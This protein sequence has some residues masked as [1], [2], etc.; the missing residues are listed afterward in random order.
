MRREAM[1]RLAFVYS[2]CDQ[3]TRYA[4]T[5]MGLQLWLENDNFC[6]ERWYRSC[7]GEGDAFSPNQMIGYLLDTILKDRDLDGVYYF[8]PHLRGKYWMYE[9]MW[10][11]WEW[12]LVEARM[13]GYDGDAIQM[14]GRIVWASRVLPSIGRF[15]PRFS[16]RN[17]GRILTPQSHNRRRY[18][19]FERDPTGDAMKRGVVFSEWKE[20]AEARNW[21]W[22]E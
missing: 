16:T 17:K 5:R 19:L 15:D 18:A 2:R 9:L 21:G 1:K 8:A 6:W 20:C 12:S 13:R 11:L 7:K 3:R 22:G 10:D 4:S 14:Q